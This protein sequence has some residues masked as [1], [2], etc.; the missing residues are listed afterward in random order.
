MGPDSFFCSLNCLPLT[1]HSSLFML[2]KRLENLRLAIGKRLDFCPFPGSPQIILESP[3]D[4][5]QDN[6][7]GNFHCFPFCDDVKFCGREEKRSS[8]LLEV[9]ACNRLVIFASLFTLSLH[10]PS[11]KGKRSTLDS[12]M[13]NLQPFKNKIR[14]VDIDGGNLVADL[15]AKT[16]RG[17][18]GGAF[19]QFSF[20]FLDDFGDEA[21]IA[22]I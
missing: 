3:L 22:K 1:P 7:E 5:F 21:H 19:S 6:R 10:C 14:L 15:G 8:P 16:S 13:K 9:I 4:S 2:V 11:T 17:D 20:D 18:D 12:L